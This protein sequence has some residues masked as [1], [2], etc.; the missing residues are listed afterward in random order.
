MQGAR[1]SDFIQIVDSA[2]RDPSIGSV[3]TGCGKSEEG[4]GKKVTN[5]CV[6]LFVGAFGEPRR[7]LVSIER[8]SQVASSDA[9]R[10][11]RV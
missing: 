3:G 4:G 6:V 8:R 10:S 9:S 11:T 2:I 7:R 5:V 1:V